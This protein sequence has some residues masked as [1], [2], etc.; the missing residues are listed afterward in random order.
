MPLYGDQRQSSGWSATTCRRVDTTHH[1]IRCPQVTNSGTVATSLSTWPTAR[2]E[3]GIRDP[4]CRGDRVYYDSHRY[5]PARRPVSASHYEA[6]DFRAT[7][8]SR[9]SASRTS[10]YV[11]ETMS[12]AA[13]PASLTYRTTKDAAARRCSAIGRLLADVALKALCIARQG[14]GYRGGST[15]RS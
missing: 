12:I 7:K 8:R 11:A 6:D 10:F 5:W 3:D 9:F 1:L 13:R 14:P 15:G 4:R 2:T